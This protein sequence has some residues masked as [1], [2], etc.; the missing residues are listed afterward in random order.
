MIFPTDN[1][2]QYTEQNPWTDDNG[3]QWYCRAFDGSDD[4]QWVPI[5]SSGGA[6]AFADLTD[7]ATADL[8]GINTPLATAL[9]G[10]LSVSTAASTYQPIG[11]YAPANGIS[12]SAI[13]GTA[14]ITTDARLSDART[15]TEHNHDSRYATTENVATTSATIGESHRGK[16]LLADT[17]T[18]T[19]PSAYSLAAFQCWI[20][21]SGTVTLAGATVYGRA[22][23]IIASLTSADGLCELQNIG[24][25]WI[26]SRGIKPI[27]EGGTGATTA[28]GAASALGLGTTNTPTFAHITVGGVTS[29]AAGEALLG[30]STIADVN[31]ALGMES[32]PLTH[33]ATLGTN[34]THSGGGV[35][36]S[37]SGNSTGY[38]DIKWT[39]LTLMAGATYLLKLEC[40]ART[41]GNLQSYLDASGGQSFQTLGANLANGVAHSGGIIVRSSTATNQLCIR[42]NNGFVGTI[43]NISLTKLP[44]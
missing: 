12:P 2:A 17:G 25:G 44:F 4:I 22:G 42:C 14:I 5:P 28:A 13:S 18:L 41:S 23:N 31:T 7:K 37:A 16:N 27:T 39:G 24:N 33:P 10:K 9:N 29:A 36:V 1:P 11:N 8:P 19:I 26:L 35:Y 40:T 15:P 32:V 38:N 3:N 30:K 20:F 43:A 6:S 21:P 34:W